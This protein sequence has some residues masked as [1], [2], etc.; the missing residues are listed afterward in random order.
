M[1][2]EDLHFETNY[3]EIS[4]TTFPFILTSNPIYISYHWVIKKC[5]DI[6]A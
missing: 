5:L 6:K 1:S 3:I 4:V 2:M